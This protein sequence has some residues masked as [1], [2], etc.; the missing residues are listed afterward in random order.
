YSYT[1]F[2]ETHDRTLKFLGLGF[3]GM[4]TWYC[5]Q[6]FFAT[7]LFGD[8]FSMMFWLMVGLNATLFRFH[9]QLQSDAHNISM[10]ENV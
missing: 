3:L 8:K 1:V 7:Y 5:V 9:R 2:K 4:W 6:S 10:P